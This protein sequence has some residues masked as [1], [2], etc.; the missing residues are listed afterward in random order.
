L[1]KGTL[2]LKNVWYAAR[3]L[4]A[5][6]LMVG[7]S[8]WSREIFIAVPILIGGASYILFLVLLRVVQKEDWR[9]S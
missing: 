2:T 7:A 6:L 1:K 4:A 5:G 9:F 8:W 3:V